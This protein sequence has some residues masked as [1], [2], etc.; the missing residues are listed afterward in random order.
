[1]FSE[2]SIFIA[3]W[4]K[5]TC[6]LGSDIESVI[7][8]FSFFFNPIRQLFHHF[9]IARNEPLLTVLTATFSRRP[10]FLSRPIDLLTYPS[11]NQLLTLLSHKGQNFELGEG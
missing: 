6:F 1:M 7:Q 10:L 2:T 3:L 4:K 8:C 5:D 9:H 11:P